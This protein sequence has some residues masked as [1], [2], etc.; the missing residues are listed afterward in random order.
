M[1]AAV[2]S[3]GSEV[4]ETVGLAKQSHLLN[5]KMLTVEVSLKNIKQSVLPFTDL[6]LN[7][8]K[9]IKKLRFNKYRSL[10]GIGLPARI[11]C[12]SNTKLPA[13][14]GLSF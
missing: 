6:K 13:V 4:L 7:T 5:K 2:R 11:S 9:R 1:A 3:A 8:T 14:G 12:I 10:S